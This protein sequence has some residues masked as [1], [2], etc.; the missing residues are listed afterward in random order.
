M[1]NKILLSDILF[2]TVTSIIFIN[3]PVYTY[4]TV[5]VYIKN[6]STRDFDVW[7]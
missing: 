2:N 1:I 4:I 5:D 6:N 7:S 3:I